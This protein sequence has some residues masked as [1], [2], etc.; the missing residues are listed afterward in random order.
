MGLQLPRARARSALTVSVFAGATLAA[1]GCIDAKQSYEEFVERQS[2]RV[3]AGAS[4]DGMSQDA[5]DTAED[6]QDTG[7]AAL[8]ACD[9]LLQ[10]N[11]DGQYFTACFPV[12]T[13]LPFFLAVTRR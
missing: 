12:A 3:D 1:S 13:Q 10:Q 11:L 7:D 4:D 6:A 2:A 8:S 5:S 9:E